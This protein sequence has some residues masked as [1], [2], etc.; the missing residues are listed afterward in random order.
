MKRD[1]A[2]ECL[3]EIALA[4]VL[5]LC[6]FVLI[7]RT[8]FAGD[9]SGPS[10]CQSVADNADRATVILTVLVGLIIAG[11]IIKRLMGNGGA[12]AAAEDSDPCADLR[13][14]AASGAVQI[15]TLEAA[16]EEA[17]LS[18]ASNDGFGKSEEPP[19]L[20]VPHPGVWVTLRP[21]SPPLGN[22]PAAPTNAEPSDKVRSAQE[23]LEAE[24]EAQSRRLA[25]LADC[26][27]VEPVPERTPLP[28]LEREIED[29]EKRFEEQQKAL[30]HEVGAEMEQTQTFLQNYDAVLSKLLKDLDDYL[31]VSRKLMGD[32]DLAALWQARGDMQWWLNVAQQADTAVQ[33][34]MILVPMM[35]EMAAAMREQGAVREA[36]ALE[37]QMAKLEAEMAERTGARKTLAGL[38]ES[39][40]RER[41]GKEILNEIKDVNFLA[42]SNKNCVSCA[43]ATESTLAGKPLQAFPDFKGLPGTALQDFY[44]QKFQ[45]VLSREQLEGVMKDFGPGSRGIVWVKWED[46]G[47]HAFNVINR[48]GQIFFPD[49]QSG[50][51]FNSWDQVKQGGGYIGFLKTT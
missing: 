13:A 31:R 19:L 24:R 15:A 2:V 3:G 34:G 44:G 23:A 41:L 33:I 4:A 14:A 25:A 42:Q 27:Q 1:R 48:D 18:S 50:K 47:A 16:V 8:A 30:R 5:S 37:K 6:V 51:F 38:N 26:E 49:G 9:C 22:P 39:I 43:I 46:G 36:M 10:D 17:K 29:L 20:R 40:Q 11:T 35:G 7:V 21:W 12:A 32:P 28:D 45:S